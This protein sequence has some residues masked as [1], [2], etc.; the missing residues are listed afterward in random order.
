V[1]EVLPLSFSLRSKE[2]N[3]DSRTIGFESGVAEPGVGVVRIKGRAGGPVEEG[4]LGDLG[5]FGG[6]SKGSGRRTVSKKGP[7]RDS[8][9]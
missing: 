6:S 5:D 7:R 1:G 9:E 8:E 3:L 2:P 4:D